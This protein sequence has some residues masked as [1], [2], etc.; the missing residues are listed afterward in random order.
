V[1]A[2]LAVSR[3]VVEALLAEELPRALGR[4]L[5]VVHGKY[6]DSAPAEFTAQVN[7]RSH[8]VRA[9]HQASVLGIVDTWQDHQ[10]SARDEDLLVVTTTVADGQIGWELRGHAMGGRARNV[11]RVDV[12]AQRFGAAEADPRI[13]REPWLVDALLDAEPPDGWPPAGTLLTRDAAIRALIVA[14]LGDHDIAD[15]ALDAGALLDWSRSGTGPDRFAALA[16]PE[17]AGLTDWLAEKAGLAAPVVMALAGTGSAVDTMALGVVGAVLSVPDVPAEVVLAYGSLLGPIRPLA[18]QLRAFTDAVAGVLERWVAEA[19]LGGR[20]SAAGAR[21]VAVVE[22]ADLL[23]ARAGIRLAL[24]GNRFL[25]SGFQARLRGLAGALSSTPDD[26]GVTA[27]EAALA[28]IDNHVLARLYPGRVAVATAAVRLTRWLAGPAPNVLSVPAGIT[29]Y[30]GEWAWVDRALDLVWAGD[31][32]DDAVVNRSY[33]QVHDAARGRRDLLDETFARVLRPWTARAAS[34]APGGALLVE[35]VLSSVAAPMAAAQ[36]PMLILLDGMNGE[37]A[38]VL[39]EQVAQRGWVEVSPVVG[40]RVA[41][42]AAVPSVPLLNRAALLSGA[43]PGVDQTD[44]PGS[45]SDRFAAFWAARH[46]GAA[47]FGQRELGGAAGHRLAEQIVAALAGD[48]VVGVVLDAIVETLARD[49]RGGLL[50]WTVDD[51]PYLRELLD[52]A[53][54]YGRPVLLLSGNGHLVNRSADSVSTGRPGEDAARWRT[55][56]ATAGEVDLSGPRVRHAGGRIV[57]PWRRDIRYSERSVGY[58][59]GASLA[60]MTAPLL[61]LVP[62]PDSVPTGWSILPPEAV[63]PPWW[64]RRPSGIVEPAGA[65]PAATQPPALRR[66][67]RAAPA[68]GEPGLFDLP[69]A[70]EAPAPVVGLGAQ[71]VGSEGYLAQRAFVRRPPEPAVVAAVLDALAAADG[72]LSLVA[73]AAHAGR[74]ARSPDFFATTLQRLLNV[75]GY[76]ILSIVDG[77]RRVRLDVPLLR[78]QFGIRAR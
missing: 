20:H 10:L 4:R 57:A 11:D 13:R 76:P 35:D 8:R 69:E 28:D 54:G 24:A 72:T 12:V 64:D 60:E 65:A 66:K 27:A 51:A 6:E 39:G 37:I 7:D 70:A 40:R 59:G 52:A 21:V 67:G 74:A 53:R 75:E 63:T 47:L 73:V 33:R 42:V 2:P 3:R 9:T 25:P 30:V 26:A 58:S 5:L 55:G 19:D 45:D 68:P 22:R 31:D 49:P 62:G 61:A 29:G 1:T 41:A 15:G 50:H 56:T 38:G 77:G 71:V 18:D 16:E 23:A 78:E 17:R 44:S 46:R 36:P 34:V 43:L 14:R 48:G 32:I